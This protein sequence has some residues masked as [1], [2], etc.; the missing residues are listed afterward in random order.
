[1]IKGID[2]CTYQGI[3]DWAKVKNDIH[4]VLYPGI[5]PQEQS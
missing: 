4:E 5:E 3:I 2:V 1:M